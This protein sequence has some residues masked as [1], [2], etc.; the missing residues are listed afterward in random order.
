VLAIMLI[1]AGFDVRM[2]RAPAPHP[3]P[4]PGRERE[5]TAR[6]PAKMGHP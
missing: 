2:M 5:L 3:S 1:K 6:K 4:L